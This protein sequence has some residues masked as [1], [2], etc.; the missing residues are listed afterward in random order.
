MSTRFKAARDVHAR[1]FHD[2][3][4][5]LDLLNGD[6]FALD[7]VGSRV[8][9]GLQEGRGLGEIAAGLALLYESDVTRIEADLT[10]FADELVRRRLVV[11]AVET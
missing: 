3:L 2:E 5:L 10:V 4:V 7:E 1:R 6:Y 11:D 8:W 9:E